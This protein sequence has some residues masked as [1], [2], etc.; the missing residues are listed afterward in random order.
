MSMQIKIIGSGSTGNSVVIDDILIDCG[1]PFNKIKDYLYDVKHLFITHIHG[2]HLKPST[3]KRIQKE[4]PHITVYANYDVAQVYRVDKVFGDDT[5]IELSQAK[6][7]QS[8]PCVHDVPTHG[9]VITTMDER[10]IYATDT[11]SLDLAP[12]GKYDTLMIESNYD[13]KKVDLIRNSCKKDYGYDVWANAKRHLSTQ[14][15]KAF[16]YTR[17]KSKKSRF[18]ELHKSRRFY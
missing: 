12:A 9:F 2:D 17:R 3:L 6:T 11:S 15:C 14:Q 7:I 4:F 13:E 10:L 8:F 5:L 16:Y 1:L 18:Y